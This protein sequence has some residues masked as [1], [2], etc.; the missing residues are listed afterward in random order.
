ME[1]IQ[2][3]GQEQMIDFPKIK[4]ILGKA[5]DIRRLMAP[6]GEEVV[7]KGSGFG[8][9]T[10]DTEIGADKILGQKLVAYLEESFR[11][12]P[13]EVEV[14]GVGR[15]SKNVS[16]DSNIDYYI[17]LDP[18]DGSLNFR[19]RGKT[20]GLPYTTALAIF[21]RTSPTY[22][23]CV[24]GGVID[25]RS[26]DIWAALRGKGATL[27]GLPCRT[28]GATKVNLKEGIVIG[29]FYYPENRELLL[30]LFK[31][32]RG[33]LRNPGS[34]AYEMAL[35]ASGQADAFI[36]DR[37]KA[38]ELGSAYLLV[39]E[40]G[41]Y[42]CDFEG[43]DLADRDYQFNSQTPVIVASTRDLALEIVGRIKST[44]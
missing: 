15:V 21:E 25:L 40:A 2:P 5:Y 3:Q 6:G 11:N 13:F 37:Q 22:K 38:H 12:I 39:A 20:L 29:E 19:L 4:G 10:N 8:E 26:G 33:W 42:V 32:E 43:Q 18:L 28:S 1:K 9:L 24:A 31:G 23:D 36:C 27:N 14:E 16:P 30:K 44:P 7:T 34:A 17:T 35:V 41:G